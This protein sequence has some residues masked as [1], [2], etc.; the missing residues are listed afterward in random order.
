MGYPVP[1]ELKGEERLFVI[2][3]INVPFYKR[4][5]IYNG[6]V[7]LIVIM[8]NK[9]LDNLIVGL[10]LLVIANAVVYPLGHR[11]ISKNKFNNGNM[12]FDKVMK[13]KLLLRLRGGGNV[14]I[15]KTK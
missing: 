11:K 15:R 3:H 14:Y 12:D 1:K 2:P 5:L 7:T 10:G 6:P 4:S 9:F 13:K 8:I